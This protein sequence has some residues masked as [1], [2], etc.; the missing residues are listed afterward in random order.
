MTFERSRLA[1]GANRGSFR[2]G[3]FPCVTCHTNCCK[4]YTVF[5]NVFDI[6]RIW[7]KLKIPPESFLEMIEAS[8]EELGVKLTDGIVDLA[9][10]KKESSEACLFLIEAGDLFRCG[11][12]EIKPGVCRAYP[13]DW[14]DGKVV[15]LEDKLCPVD[16]HVDREFEKT[17]VDLHRDLADEWEFTHSL[18][19]E[20]NAM[21]IPSRDF[22][23]YV[24]YVFR[25]VR[26]RERYFVRIDNS[27]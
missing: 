26:E 10:K 1:S 19:A 23:S 27:S 2:A 4:A 8:N 17:I 13:F 15:Q 14:R 18:I 24:T 11:I 20:W 21:S 22:H 3:E 12:H 5:P 7:T 6:Y 25:R 9:L 16:W